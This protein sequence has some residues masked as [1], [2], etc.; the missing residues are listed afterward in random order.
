MRVSAHTTSR[1]TR[2]VL[3]ASDF[4]LVLDI[5]VIVT[6]QMTVCVVTLCKYRVLNADGY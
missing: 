6:A 3:D 4:S 1:Y 2:K 5:D